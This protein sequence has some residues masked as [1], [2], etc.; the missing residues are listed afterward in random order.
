MRYN[1]FLSLLQTYFVIAKT[2]FM[3][4]YK[5][6]YNFHKPW[7]WSALWLVVIIIIHPTRIPCTQSSGY[8]IGRVFLNLANRICYFYTLL[9]SFHNLWSS[10]TQKVMN[11]KVRNFLYTLELAWYTKAQQWSKTCLLDTYPV[12]YGVLLCTPPPHKSQHMSD[13]VKECA[14]HRVSRSI[15]LSNAVFSKTKQP[16]LS[17]FK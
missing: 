5:C 4:T 2:S 13:K 8:Y 7:R 10:S 17:C 11:D 3:Y 16:T 12:F 9:I 15:E 14:A 6:E 1:M